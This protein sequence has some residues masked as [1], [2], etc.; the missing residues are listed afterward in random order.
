LDADCARVLERM[1]GDLDGYSTSPTIEDRRAIIRQMALAYGPA[2]D[3]AE[4]VEDRLIDT[5]AGKLPLRIYWPLNPAPAQPLLLHIHGGGWSI[6]DPVAYERVCRAY[7]A[8]GGCIVVDVHY[9]RA[10]ENKYP[11]ALD[12]C[13][14][15]LAWVTANAETLGGDPAL[16]GV[17]GDSAGGNLAA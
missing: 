4:R 12:D 7:C 2:P 5:P 6:G 13:E 10:P 16:I 11:A 9:R 8:A 17:T 1:A 3:A 14:A 15:A